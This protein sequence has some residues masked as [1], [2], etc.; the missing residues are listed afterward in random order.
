MLD[1]FYVEVTQ[2]KHC[3]IN[4]GRPCTNLPTAIWNCVRRGLDTFE[5]SVCVKPILDSEP[6]LLSPILLLTGV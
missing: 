5:V 2:V 3:V 1:D 6:S 4:L